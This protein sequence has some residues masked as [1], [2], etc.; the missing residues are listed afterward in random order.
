M[1]QWRQ[2]AIWLLFCVAS[3]AHKAENMPKPLLPQHQGEL[4]AAAGRF[5]IEGRWS[6]GQIITNLGV[7]MLQEAPKVQWGSILPSFT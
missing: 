5:G 4:Q 6:F 1:G 3:Q 7:S 2:C